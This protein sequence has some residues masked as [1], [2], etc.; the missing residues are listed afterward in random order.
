ML[1]LFPNRP[2]DPC[3]CQH[4]PTRFIEIPSLHITLGR[5]CP[6]FG[7]VITHSNFQLALALDRHWL[8][9]MFRVHPMQP[10]PMPLH[11][12]SVQFLSSPGAVQ[13]IDRQQ[14]L[15]VHSYMPPQ[16]RD[17]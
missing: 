2:Y 10:P 16:S 8:K 7:C 1:P 17:I 5:S 13:V 12:A 4:R 6:F 15:F 9:P 11:Y 14:G 3:T